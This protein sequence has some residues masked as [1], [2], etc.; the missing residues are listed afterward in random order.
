MALHIA[1]LLG[2]NPLRHVAV[3]SFKTQLASLA[4]CYLIL[5]L[6]DRSA[7]RG[8]LDLEGKKFLI[9][10]LTTVAVTVSLYVLKGLHSQP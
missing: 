4:P 9:V 6:T 3:L 2:I 5:S 1:D 10:D 7:Q 8:G